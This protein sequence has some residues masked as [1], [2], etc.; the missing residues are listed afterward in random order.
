VD[1]HLCQGAD[2]Q[3]AFIFNLVGPFFKPI[4]NPTAKSARK[5]TVHPS[6]AYVKAPDLGRFHLGFYLSKTN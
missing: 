6:F 4:F 1:E 2:K 3:Y 5:N